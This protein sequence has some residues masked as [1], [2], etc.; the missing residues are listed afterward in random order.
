M[1][2]QELITDVC[3]YIK[4]KIVTAQ[5]V[6]EGKPPEKIDI[7]RKEIVDDTL[8]VFVNTTKGKGNIEDVRLLDEDGHVL[9]SKPKGVIKTIDHAIVS[10]FWIRVTEQELA[11][12][13]SIFERS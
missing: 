5:V 7:M 12:P 4:D 1:L 8:K 9:I 3:T 2:S 10:T 13:I 11:N 6:F